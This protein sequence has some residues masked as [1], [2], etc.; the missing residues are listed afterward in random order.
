ME[1]LCSAIIPQAALDRLALVG[2]RPDLHMTY[3]QL[4]GEAVR[5][6]AE[7]ARHHGFLPKRV[8]LMLPAGPEFAVAAVA[9]L[10]WGGAVAPIDPSLRG[11]SLVDAFQA[12]QP[13]L[14]ITRV[15]RAGMLRGDA[16]LPEVCGLD[17]SVT[18]EGPAITVDTGAGGPHRSSHDRAVRDD[19]GQPV[20]GDHVHP[21]DDALLLSTSGTTGKPKFVR[22]SQRAVIGNIR[23]HL[24]AFGLNQPYTALQVLPVNYSYGF[25]ASFLATL[26]AGG[27]VIFPEH[28]D[29]K[30]V[31]QAVDRHHPEV[32]LGTP[33]FFRHLLEGCVPEALASFRTLK[34][35]GVG[36]DAC[37]PPQRA[38]LRE[39]LPDTRIHIT[40]GTT[41]CGPRVATLP[42][43]ML[44]SK[45]ASIGRPF[46]EVRIEIRTEDGRLSD[47]GAIGFL[48]IQTPSLMTGYLNP[49]GTSTTLEPDHWYRTGDLAHL[50]ADGC[51]FLH[52]RADRQWKFRGRR[53]NPSMI[54]RSLAS[55]AKVLHVRADRFDG[56]ADKIRVTIHHRP[57]AGPSI[58]RELLQLCR[59]NLP[60]YL[61]PDELVLHADD[62]IYF[63]G[64]RW[65]A[66]PAAN[67]DHATPDHS[68][69]A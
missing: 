26:V 49:D 44:V 55:H 20:F 19:A 57:D 4:E 46:P 59:A 69:A 22:L 53:I 56:D 16:D 25:V 14:M 24:A 33:A 1:L 61:M 31:Q 7:I 64:K 17:C 52:G 36:G 65:S 67:Q 28:P 66:E 40:Y 11:Q 34:V 38:I 50:D 23:M 32:C 37:H 41:E 29:R 6:T 45:A 39:A 18:A 43:E 9:V 63:K 47:P 60:S 35:L 30:H 21:D 54:E 13:D 5:F 48:H 2:P 8:A 68:V 62:Q 12:L 51:L 42:P 15:G 3:A 27:T 58:H 10:Q